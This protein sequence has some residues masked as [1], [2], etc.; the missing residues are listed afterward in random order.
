MREEGI[1]NIEVH[2]AGVCFNEGNVLILKRSP[3][4][5]LYPGLWECGGG[6]VMPN[7][8]FEEAVVRQLR[9]E[10][11]VLVEPINAFGTYQIVKGD[12]KIPGVKIVCR[13]LGYADGK[14]LK[15]SKEHTECKWQPMFR[16]SGLEMIP[17]TAKDIKDA[18]EELREKC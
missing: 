17:G 13:F 16:L 6:Q 8:S 15:I 2:V 5:E 7:E 1:C 3:T 14:G 10:T 11:G 9:E 12:K 18:Y 4:R